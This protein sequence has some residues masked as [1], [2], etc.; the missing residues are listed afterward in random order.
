MVSAVPDDILLLLFDLAV[1]TAPLQWLDAV[2][3]RERAQAPFAL[4]A[5]C[6]R[7]RALAI[8]TASLWTYFGFPSKLH[9]QEAHLPRLRTLLA[10][11]KEAEVDVVCLWSITEA[12]GV[13]SFA[14]MEI[15]AAIAAL[16]PRW[17]FAVLDI[18]RSLIT[19]F[20]PALSKPWSCL[21]SLSLELREKISGLPLSPQLAEL[22]LDVKK[23]EWPDPMNALPSLIRL[24]LNGDGGRR[25]GTLLAAISQQLTE[26]CILND[27][28]IPPNQPITFPRLQSL[29]LDD[30]SHLEHI[31][32][33]TLNTLTLNTAYLLHSSPS[34]A[35]FASV[36]HLCLYVAFG[37]GHLHSLQQ[38]ADIEK[39]SF[40]VSEYSRR[41][42]PGVDKYIIEQGSFVALQ[43]LSN[44]HKP[45]W[46]RLERI[47]LGYSGSTE[48]DAIPEPQELIDFVAYRNA[49]HEGDGTRHVE[50]GSD[51]TRPARIQDVTVDF[52]GATD[53]LISDLQKAL[54]SS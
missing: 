12:V 9:V 16:A 41:T 27:I 44:S 43:K 53:G 10:R 25:D 47:R 7:W 37:E 13:L 18:P 38:L 20:R 40:Q 14:G 19:E 33:P 36:R 46:P 4:A 28:I 50:D 24:F 1:Q 45:I 39:L 6:H 21:Q 54:V 2:Y 22:H 29:T 8:S 17:R 34:F 23:V 32:A 26:L 11:S 15:M 42:W 51:H 30:V 48:P 5:V 35:P 3:E 31:R 49:A 52:D